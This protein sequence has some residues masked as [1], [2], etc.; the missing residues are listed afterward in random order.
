VI[1][2]VVADDQQ[3]VRTGFRMILDA[4]P[5]LDVVGEAADGAAAVCLAAQLHPD[6]ILMDIRMPQLDG[7]EA[8][9]L[10]LKRDPAIRVLI[11]TTFDL[12]EYVYTALE[13]GA[14]GFLLKDVRATVL[15]DAVRTVHLGDA[16]IAPSVTRRLVE[17]FVSTRPAIPTS[18]TAVA[19]LTD[20]EREVLQMIARGLSNTDIA[21]ALVLSHATIKTHISRIFAKLDARDRTQAVIAAYQ[22]G[23]VKPTP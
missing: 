8:T 4:E 2:I 6:I 20:R 9:R 17:Q 10:I 3:L 19:S 5:D 1:R 14:S 11:L 13:A 15:A 16:I 23:L 12:D 18:S 7:I 22:A 21:A